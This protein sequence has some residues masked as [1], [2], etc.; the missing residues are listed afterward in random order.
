MGGAGGRSGAKDGS[1]SATGTGQCTNVKY[2]PL[3]SAARSSRRRLH[4]PPN[5]QICAGATHDLVK[6]RDKLA[7]RRGYEFVYSV[8]WALTERER[9]ALRLALET[10]REAAIDANGKIRERRSHEACA[11]EKCGHRGCWIEE[12]HAI[13]LTC[14]LRKGP[15]GDRLKAWPKTMRVFARRDHPHPPAL[16]SPC[17]RPPT[18]GATPCEP[19]T[20]R[21]IRK[22]GA[23]RA[24]TSTQ[25]TGSTPASRT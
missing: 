10:A 5:R 1:R 21:R 16:S 7:S 23:A 11:N 4:D 20:C 6:R 8:G 13:E 12:A 17:S 14:L 3:Y 9:T 18:G 19:R 15:D 22:A 25:A 2:P 24:P